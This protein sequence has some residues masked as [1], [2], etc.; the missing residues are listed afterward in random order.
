[1]LPLPTPRLPQRSG[2]SGNRDR[3]ARPALATTSSLRGD[4]LS[5]LLNSKSCA[6]NQQTPVPKLPEHDEPTVEE[7]EA[8]IRSAVGGGRL[9][10][11]ESV[12]RRQRQCYEVIARY[13]GALEITIE[14]MK[15]GQRPL[16]VVNRVHDVAAIGGFGEGCELS[17]VGMAV[18]AIA[19]RRHVVA[20]P[21]PPASLDVALSMLGRKARA[22]NFPMYV[23]LCEPRDWV[24]PAPRLIGPG[25]GP[26]RAPT[27]YPTRIWLQQ[28]MVATNRRPVVKDGQAKFATTLDATDSDVSSIEPDESGLWWGVATI[29]LDQSFIATDNEPLLG[30]VSRFR[31]LSWEPLSRGEVLAQLAAAAVSSRESLIYVH[32]YNT[33]LQFAARTAALYARSFRRNVVACFAWP[34]NPPLPKSWAISAVLSVAERNYTAAEQMLQRSVP[35]LGAFAKHLRAALPADC[36]ILWKAHSMGCYLTLAALERILLPTHDDDAAKRAAQLQPF[37]RIVLD[38]PD[39]P[40][41]FFV[42]VLSRAA[43]RGSDVRFLHYFNPSDEAVELARQR[44]GLSFPAPGNGCVTPADLLAVQVVDCSNTKA[45]IG[46][47]DYGRLDPN[48]LLDQRMFFDAILPEDR[49]LVHIDDKNSKT[50][51]WAFP[52]R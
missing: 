5:S 9:S 40:T 23:Q 39:C 11:R 8:E 17:V 27:I 33:N 31:F 21:L 47:H 51:V 38:A 22:E 16:L 45:S 49:H 2:G 7:E 32:G 10:S 52:P 34:S 1:M 36:Q 35:A 18:A 6:A 28:V 12:G 44:R 19:K 4:V 13:P 29:G 46:K 42:D 30:E 37:A 15:Q 41:W 3:A 26:P 24:S 20:Q 14:S 50:Q 25:A 43:Q 48:C